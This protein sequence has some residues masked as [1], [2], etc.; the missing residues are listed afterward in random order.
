[1]A[2]AN[3]RGCPNCNG[4]AGPGRIAVHYERIMAAFTD[5]GIFGPDIHAL[6]REIRDVAEVTAP[7]R[8]G[9]MAKAHFINILP[10]R[11]YQRTFYVG[12]RMGYAPF[13][14]GGTAGKG[15]GFIDAKP[16]RLMELR[17]IPYSWFR[18][19]SPGRFRAQVRGQE[20]NNWLNMALRLAVERRLRGG[21]RR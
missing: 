4:T 19:D 2:R 10:P 13:V 6:S 12:N 21:R 11:G 9:R 14:L 7:K 3:L 5:A 15:T 1:M 18:A 20:P 17:P 16:P 8:T